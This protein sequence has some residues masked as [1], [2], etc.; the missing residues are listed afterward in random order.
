MLKHFDADDK[1]EP[2]FITLGIVRV[3]VRAWYPSSKS[4]ST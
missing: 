3:E 2:P 4:M 1:M